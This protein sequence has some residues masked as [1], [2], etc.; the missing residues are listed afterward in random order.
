MLD[1]VA[2]NNEVEKEKKT[3]LEEFIFVIYKKS[4]N[5]FK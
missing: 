2:S 3:A 1:N 4:I 5:N